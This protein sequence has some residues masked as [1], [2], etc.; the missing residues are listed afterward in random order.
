MVHILLTF[1]KAER[2]GQGDLHLK[3][4]KQMLAFLAAAGHNNYTKS[5]YLYLQKMERLSTS[6]PQVHEHFRHGLHINHAMQELTEVCYSTSEQH[7]DLS[8]VRQEKDTSDIA[9][10][11]DFLKSRNPFDDN[12]GLG[13]IVTEVEED[14]SVNAD[15]AQDVGTDWITSSRTGANGLGSEVGYTLFLAPFDPAG[16]CLNGWYLWCLVLVQCACQFHSIKVTF[17]SNPASQV[18]D[19]DGNVNFTKQ[20]VEESEEAPAVSILLLCEVS[21]DPNYDQ[22]DVPKFEWLVDGKEVQSTSDKLSPDGRTLNILDTSGHNYT[23]RVSSSLG[24]RETHYNTGCDPSI[25][26]EANCYG[27]TAERVIMSF[28][29]GGCL[30]L[31]FLYWCER[32]KPEHQR[33]ARG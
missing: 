18:T 8:A 7:K 6:Y 2:T 3:M 32:T 21:H 22:W 13:S 23:C 26:E 20:I 16:M 1:I 24:T 25:H 17:R 27:C 19:K 28:A 10:C 9:V 15:N 12:P 33:V 30:V 14:A 31:S 5:L 29:L 11:L 4:S